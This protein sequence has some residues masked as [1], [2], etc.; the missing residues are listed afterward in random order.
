[1]IIEQSMITGYPLTTATEAL[2]DSSEIQSIVSL[3]TAALPQLTAG[4]FQTFRS[5]TVRSTIAG[6]D[7]AMTTSQCITVVVYLVK[8]GSVCGRAAPDYDPSYMVRSGR[9]WIYRDWTHCNRGT[10][11]HELGHALGYNHVTTVPSIMNPVSPANI[12]PFDL[13]AVT[14]AFARPPGNRAPDIDPAAWAVNTAAIDAGGHL[15]TPL[16]IP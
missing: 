7:V 10:V 6:D 1:L 8:D 13:Q 11:V 9:V 3:M 2:L 5:I 16:E 12:Q 4:T 15:F 14:V